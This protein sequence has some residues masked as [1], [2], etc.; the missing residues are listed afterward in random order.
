MFGTLVHMGTAGKTWKVVGRESSRCSPNCKCGRHLMKNSGQFGT[1]KFLWPSGADTRSK[2]GWSETARASRKNPG[3][4]G[5]KHTED[6]KARIAEG[7]RLLHG[8]GTGRSRASGYGPA[9][10]ELRPAVLE[11]DGYRCVL[12]EAGSR[13]HV[14]HL[15]YDKGHNEEGNLVTLC[16]TCHMRGHRAEAWPIDLA[17]SPRQPSRYHGVARLGGPGPCQGLRRKA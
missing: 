17:V 2:A 8:N 13:L 11:R 4:K 15:D 7:I 3:G 6:A 16:A 9:Y 14:H 1:R 10:Y 5:F 12:C